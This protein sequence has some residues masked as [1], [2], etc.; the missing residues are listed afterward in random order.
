MDFS[1]DTIIFR[2][3]FSNMISLGFPRKIIINENS[4]KFNYFYFVNLFIVNFYLKVW[5]WL[6]TVIIFEYH[7]ISF[8]LYLDIV[9][10]L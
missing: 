1:D 5:V 10:Y 2:D 4:P 7:E 8:Y 6:I 9:Y 3:S